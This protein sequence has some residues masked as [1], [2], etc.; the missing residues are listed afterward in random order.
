[1]SNDSSKDHEEVALKNVKVSANCIMLNKTLAVV[2]IVLLDIVLLV[3]IDK[4]A[5][6]LI[7]IG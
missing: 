5:I 3:L 7:F 6:F 2:L 1:M 4:C